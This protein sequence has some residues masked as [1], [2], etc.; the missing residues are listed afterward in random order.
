[1]GD[2]EQ[3]LTDFDGAGLEGGL[4]LRPDLLIDVIS[5]D[6]EVL[7][8]NETQAELLG[9]YDNEVAGMDAGAFYSPESLRL[10]LQVLRNR[11]RTDHAGTLELTLLA[12]GGR[13]IATLARAR[14]IRWKGEMALRLV[15]IDLGPVGGRFRQVEE[16]LRTLSSMVETSTEAHWSIAFLEPVDTTLPKSEVVRQVFENQSVWRLCNP[17]MARIYNIPESVEFNDQDVRL[18]W[19]RSAANERFV[20]EIINSSYAINDA[21]SVDRVHDGTLRYILNDV[22]GE[23]IDG[24][25]MRLWGNCRDVTDLRNADDEKT[26][27]LKMTLKAFDGLPDPVM[28]LDREGRVLGRNRA[29]AAAFSTSRTFETQLQ[30]FVRSRRPSRGWSVFTHTGGAAAQTILA[31]VH[32]RRVPGIGADDWTVVTLRD[33]AGEAKTRARRQKRFVQG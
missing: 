19:P 21:L 32:V 5:R 10:I 18:Y 31:D 11:S 4:A 6:G 17:A 33:H 25:L 8:F 27:L 26:N 15:K 7:W 3:L 20:E 12:R 29:Y 16:D 14:L 24:F 23:I 22:R 1:M 9:T 2:Y 13:T 30:A 28:I